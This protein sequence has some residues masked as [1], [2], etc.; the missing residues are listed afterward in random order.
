MSQVL[1]TTTEQTTA[2]AHPAPQRPARGTGWRRRIPLLPALIFTIALTQVPFLVTLVVSLMNWNPLFPNEIGF[3]WFANYIT[4]FTNPTLLSSVLASLVITVSVV[5]ISLVLGLG[6]A[7]LLNQRF[8]GRGIVRTMIIAPFL[9]VPV[10]AA[11]LWKHLLLNPSYGLINGVIAWL[12]NL[13]GVQVQGPSWVTDFPIASIVVV[14]VWQ[15]TPFMTLIILAG[16]QSQPGDVIEAARVDGAGGWRIFRYITIPHVR[17]YLELSTL[18]GSIYV[19]Q[20]FDAVFTLTAGAFGTANLPYTIYRTFFQA[21]D[22][23]VGSAMGVVTVA[24]TILIMSLFLRSLTS[25]SEE[26]VR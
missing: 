25:L 19:F 11:L 2:A 5:L 13:V 8:A 23:G 9:F 14:L 12:G 16:L 17:R 3:A 22:Y 7:L 1:D 4:V 24:G 6:I 15:W 26:N 21:Q 10:A 18:L 20:N